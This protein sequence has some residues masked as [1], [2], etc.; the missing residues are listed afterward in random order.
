MSASRPDVTGFRAPSTATP[1]RTVAVPPPPAPATPTVTTLPA[2]PPTVP[3]P[4]P[5]QAKPAVEVIEKPKASKPPKEK[6]VDLTDGGGDD[7]TRHNFSVAADLLQRCRAEADQQDIWLS[8]VARTALVT[9]GPELTPPSPNGRRRSRRTT[10]RVTF[11]VIL[12][13]HE[14]AILKAAAGDH[15]TASWV[16]QQVLEQHLSQ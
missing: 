9:Y 5:A 13:S 10:N 3:K 4:K 12:S 15:G 1:E 16:I 11:T 7:F 2:A 14:L 8:D 6:V